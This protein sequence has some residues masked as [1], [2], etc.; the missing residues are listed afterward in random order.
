[1]TIVDRDKFLAR[2]D[3]DLHHGN[4]P[5]ALAMTDLDG[6]ADVNARR[7]HAA[8]DELLVAWEVALEHNLPDGTRVE[9]L[10]GDEYAVLMPGLSAE[11]ALILVD[12]LRTFFAGQEIASGDGVTV[13]A[14]V[15][16]NPPHGS[17][18]EDLFRAAGQALM[19]AKREGRNRVA[20]FVEEKMVMKSNYYDR[21]SLERLSKLSD[22]MGRTD[23]SLLR[24]A[25]DDLFDKY[26]EEL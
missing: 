1:M 21:G 9:R 2:L 14:G 12:E 22:A 15:A 19:R 13:S 16:S 3:R 10:G 11:S 6:F 18:A 25:L 24:E 26:S 4:A 7:G 20:I 8:G 17:T 23:A 5:L